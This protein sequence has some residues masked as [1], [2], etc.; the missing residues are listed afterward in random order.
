MRS[1][2]SAKG[3][4]R[5]RRQLQRQKLPVVD[6]GTATLVAGTAT[7]TTTRVTDD[8]II[9]LTGQ[10]SGGTEAAVYV[11]ARVAGTS[12]TITSTDAG[13]TQLVAWVLLEP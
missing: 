3:E 1:D 2:R 12:F 8:S 4:M 9:L 13:N 7:V 11:S 5:L 6:F 10:G